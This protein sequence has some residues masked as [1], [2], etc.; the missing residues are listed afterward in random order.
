MP[1]DDPFDDIFEDIERWLRDVFGP[2]GGE[3]RPIVDARG[4][5][6]DV[7]E[8]DDEVEVVADLPGVDA[9]EV[10]ME[11][12]GETLRIVAGNHDNDV[13]LPVP[14]DETSAEAQFNNGVLSVAFDPAGRDGARLDG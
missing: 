5:R 1:G 3:D 8:R 11:C 10:E 12:D 4:T 9:H 7:S 6:V 13:E 14:V 2:D